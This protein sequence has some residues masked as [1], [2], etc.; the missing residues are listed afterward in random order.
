MNKSND[1]NQISQS[2]E[3]SSLLL[4]QHTSE[5]DVSAIQFSIQ[6]FRID[7]RQDKLSLTKI[8][9]NYELKSTCMPQYL[10]VNQRIKNKLDKYFCNQEMDIPKDECLQ[11]NYL[12][13]RKLNQ[14][15]QQ[16]SDF[17]YIYV[18]NE[19]SEKRQEYFKF[20]FGPLYSFK[21][22]QIELA[23]N[24]INILFQQCYKLIVMKKNRKS[25]KFNSE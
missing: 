16:L 2:L 5:N 18:T 12:I 6:E 21:L 20:K 7:H 8:D 9:E 11:I 17:Y 23:F 1:L 25:L 24:L 10:T 4:D 14:C 19:V 13:K 15:N 3:E 22:R